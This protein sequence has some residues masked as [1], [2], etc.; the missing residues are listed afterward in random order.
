[1]PEISVIMAVY[2]GEKYTALAIESILNQTYQ[3]FEFIIID[4]GS[5]D[6]TREIVE[7]YAQKDPRIKLIVN[8]ANQ[9][10]TK[11]LNKALAATNGSFI[12]RMDADDIAHIERF[13]KQ[14]SYLKNNPHIK[15]LG[16]N[17]VIIDEA[18]EEVKKVYLARPDLLSHLEHR[19]G[20]VHGSMMYE[21]EVLKKVAG[22]NEQFILAQDY[23]LTLRLIEHYPVACLD[24]Y[25]YFLRRTKENISTKKFF[26]QLY[27]TALAKYQHVLR[28]KKYLAKSFIRSGVWIGELLYS[29]VYIGKCGLP[30]LLNKK[31]SKKY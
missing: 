4:D 31:R 7:N 5:V 27:F 16:S 9:G 24:E 25:L 1:M 23:D 12:A 10:L 18:G 8:Q 17:V 26:T 19:N 28:K 29:Y 22:Y 21:R 14:L 30:K 20:L 15:A 13:E 2:N 11:S 6:R 3:D